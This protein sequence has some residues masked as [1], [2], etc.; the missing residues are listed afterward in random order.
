LLILTLSALKERAAAAAAGNSDLQE[1]QGERE[2]ESEEGEGDTSA[3]KGP[4][5]LINSNAVSARQKRKLLARLAPS[6]REH[7]TKQDQQE[8]PH[9]PGLL[10]ASRALGLAGT[11]S[12]EAPQVA[13]VHTNLPVATCLKPGHQSY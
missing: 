7:K 6:E 10:L 9:G 12:R 3:F 5:T 4:A 8:Q 11:A 1:L 2:K 13:A